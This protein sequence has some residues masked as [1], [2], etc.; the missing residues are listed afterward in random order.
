MAKIEIKGEVV[1]LLEKQNFTDSVKQTVVIHEVEKTKDGGTFES[2]I[3]IDFWGD[4]IQ[5]I[6]NLKTGDTVEVAASIRSSEW[7]E[8]YYTNV[9]GFFCK[10]VSRAQDTA[11]DEAHEGV[12]EGVNDLPF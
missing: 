7:K 2:D 5:K 10:T 4:K 3:A 9:Y 12:N 6:E 1:A 11:Q 8:K